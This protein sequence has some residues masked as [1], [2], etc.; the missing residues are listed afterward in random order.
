MARAHSLAVAR[1]PEGGPLPRAGARRIPINLA[2]AGS[3]CLLLLA[4]AGLV[5]WLGFSTGFHNTA[6]LLHDKTQLTV[7]AIEQR[8]RAQLDPVYQ[9]VSF[10]AE[11]VARGE[12]DPLDPAHLDPSLRASMAAAPQVHSVLYIPSTLQVR[13]ASRVYPGGHVN[14]A[15]LDWAGEERYERAL[16]EG[17]RADGPYWG[18]IV[19][20]PRLSD[21]RDGVLL[22]VRAPVR[23]DG[24]FL[25]LVAASVRLDTLSRLLTEVGA[26]GGATAFI[27]SGPD[28]VVAHPALVDG[29]G[30]R[31]VDAPLPGVREIDDPVLQALWDPER[32]RTPLAFQGHDEHSDGSDLEVY[33]VLVG[34]GVHVAALQWLYGYGAVPWRVGVH[35]RREDIGSEFRALLAAGVASVIAL[36]LSIAAMWFIGGRISRPVRRL[37]EAAWQLRRGGPSAVAPLRGSRLAE[38]DTAHEAFNEMLAGMRQREILRDSFGKFVPETIAEQL[39]SQQ[40]SL[41]PVTRVATV[42]FTDIAGFST[43]SEKIAPHAVIALLNE[44]F[45]ALIEPIEHHGG[46]IHQFQGDAILATFNLPVED[47]HH[48]LQAVRAAQ[49]IQACVQARRFGGGLELRTR[50][51]INTGNVVGGTVGGTGRLGYTVHGD[52]VNLAARIESL[53]KT[54]GTQV[55]VAAETVALCHGA[56]A[57]REVGTSEVRGREHVVRLFTPESAERPG[58]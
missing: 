53:N 26:G 52:A 43:I 24:E 31:T 56:I 28:L 17:R 27:L 48:A 36:L 51:G 3:F 19:Y 16:A 41:A 9:Q 4:S 32:S 25:G 30:N 2:L 49:A 38:V 5:L 58:E 7:D 11:L 14:A 20:V 39:L 45:S 46:V 29:H 6:G 50:V 12:L 57:F 44:Y 40:G 1:V 55:L 42:M 35:F 10:L 33:R 13:V 8:A 15:S 54:F 23:R 34:D 47:P 21:G 37:A 18:E 22:N